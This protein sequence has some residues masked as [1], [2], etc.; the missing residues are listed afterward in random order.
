[1]RACVYIQRL[2]DKVGLLPK[3]VQRAV[4]V[5]VCWAL[6]PPAPAFARLLSAP[7]SLSL[8]LSLWWVVLNNTGWGRMRGQPQGSRAL[9][10]ARRGCGG[11]AGCPWA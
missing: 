11:P 7:F 4:C 9:K 10:S 2:R 8:S 1:M 5:C 6:W 3:C